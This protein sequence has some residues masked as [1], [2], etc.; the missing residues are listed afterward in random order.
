MTNDPQV[1]ERMLEQTLRD[2]QSDYVDGYLIHWPDERVDIRKPYEILLR[3]KEKGRIRWI[4]LCNSNLEDLTKVSQLLR[5]E[6]LQGPYSLFDRSSSAEMLHFAKQ[7]SVTFMAYGV[8]EKGLLSGRVTSDRRY[9]DVDARSHAPWWKKLNLPARYKAVDA[10]QLLL[11]SEKPEFSLLDLAVHFAL[12][13]KSITTL[14]CGT[15][16]SEQLDS[17]KKSLSKGVPID[18]FEDA[19]A[20]VDKYLRKDA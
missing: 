9:D 2:I 13:N 5:P 14:V 18:L 16:S 7:N 12:N 3:A 10:L 1:T 4:G 17:L 15:R 20:T 11:L 6:I 19:C 8:L